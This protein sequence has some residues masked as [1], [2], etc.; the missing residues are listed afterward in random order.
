MALTP[1]HSNEN[2]TLSAFA[3]LNIFPAGS[4][5]SSSSSFQPDA[6]ATA[7][8]T[9]S[10][11]SVPILAPVIKSTGGPTKRIWESHRA[12]IKQLYLEENKSL[13]EVMRLM[14]SEHDFK[15]T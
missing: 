13:A 14:R 8:P 1:Y 15:A 3:G 11:F 12:L 9:P 10:I 7:L 2:G 5:D 6:S 4:L